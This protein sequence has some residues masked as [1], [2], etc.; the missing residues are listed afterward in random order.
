MYQTNSSYFNN[1][2]NKFLATSNYQDFP[3]IKFTR[4]KK[5]KPGYFSNLEKT[6]YNSNQNTRYLNNLSTYYSTNSYPDLYLSNSSNKNVFL[7]TKKN[8]LL[9]TFS[10]KNKEETITTGFFPKSKFLNNGKKIEYD[11]ENKEKLDK[12]EKIEKQE[13]KSLDKFRIKNLEYNGPLKINNNLNLNTTQISTFISPSNRFNNIHNHNNTTTNSNNNYNSFNNFRENSTNIYNKDSNN[14]NINHQNESVRNN[15]YLHSVNITHNAFN[16]TQSNK[17]PTKSNKVNFGTNT[18]Y[19]SYSYVNFQNKENNNNNNSNHNNDIVSAYSGNKTG[20]NFDCISSNLNSIISPNYNFNNI[21]HNNYSNFSKFQKNVNLFKKNNLNNNLNS[22]FD[23]KNFALKNSNRLIPLNNNRSLNLRD[24]KEKRVNMSDFDHFDIYKEN[25]LRMR[26]EQFLKDTAYFIFNKTNKNKFKKFV[27]KEIPTND[28]FQN[29]IDKITRLVEIKKN[30]NEFVSVEY[31]VNM[32]KEE[33]ENNNISPIKIKNKDMLL[34][35][36]NKKNPDIENYLNE[37]NLFRRLRKNRANINNKYFTSSISEEVENYWE[38]KNNKNDESNASKL[39]KDKLKISDNYVIKRVIK[40]GNRKKKMN[41]NGEYYDSELDEDEYNNRDDSKSRKKKHKKNRYSSNEYEDYEDDSY[42]EYSSNVEGN[43]SDHERRR[44]R[45]KYKKKYGNIPRTSDIGSKFFGN[46]E[47]NLDKEMRFLNT[48]KNFFMKRLDSFLITQSSGFD[49]MSDNM[50]R[51][52]LSFL[53]KFSNNKRKNRKQNSIVNKEY[54]GSQGSEYVPIKAKEN[55]EEYLTLD[56]NGNVVNKKDNNYNNKKI[57]SNNLSKKNSTMNSPNRLNDITN[58]N[59]S[60]GNI[61]LIK[62][63]SLAKSPR[64]KLNLKDL[65]KKKPTEKNSDQ[66]T[67]NNTVTINKETEGKTIPTNE[68]VDLEG[69]IKLTTENDENNALLN[70]L[71]GHLDTDENKKTKK[72]IKKIIQRLKEG[73]TEGNEEYEDIEIEVTDPEDDD[74]QENNNQNEIIEDKIIEDYETAGI[75]DF[76][77]FMESLNVIEENKKIN[78]EEVKT[79]NTGK[80]YISYKFFKYLKIS[81]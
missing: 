51:K 19:N 49:G 72:K 74:I 64:K 71:H 55:Y 35:L 30:N 33:I 60:D 34:P 31:I 52:T 24:A 54:N 38:N 46:L 2:N 32:L 53:D 8:N 26:E 59:T 9:S 18:N 39:I 68:N 21:N 16:T 42:S 22:E 75:H 7:E 57:N 70:Y 10:T 4:M 23:I 77:K 20:K 47:N 11:F 50:L 58:K 65:K 79:E 78:E 56:S 67:E 28:Y 61:N 1:T 48:Q 63:K 17:I 14:L 12:S 69:V 62:G 3:V 81:D 6:N 76:R 45:R 66:N 15:S 27:F 5:D 80:K 29:V 41:S 73:S 44:K 25:Y 36:I 13:F 37:K 40:A 43:L